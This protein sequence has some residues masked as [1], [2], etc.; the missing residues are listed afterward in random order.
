MKPGSKS[1]F[2]KAGYVLSASIV[3]LFLLRFFFIDVYRIPSESMMNK[4]MTDDY[5]LINKTAYSGYFSRF[6]TASPQQGDIFVFTINKDIPGFFVK[7]CIGL[8]GAVVAVKNG[9][10]SVNGKLMSEPR[11]V[12]HYYK[13]W[14]NDYQQVKTAIEEMRIDRFKNGFR[15]FPHY[16]V[17]ALD[18]FQKNKMNH[19]VDSIRIWNRK[20]DPDSAKINLP[21]L[22]EN[23]LD[24]SSLKIPFKGMTIYF[25]Q[26]QDTVYSNAIRMYEDSSFRL[27]SKAAFIAG[28]QVVA[29]TFKKDYFFMMGDNR[30]IAI[31]S[32]HYGFIPGD[33]LIGKFIQQF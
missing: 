17:L 25:S 4:L 18:N 32:R 20:N 29:Y 9:E 7:R 6:I 5:I 27:G 15:H 11:S 2:I 26:P 8:P 31:D 14:F 3:T 24:M 28:K 23:I 13:I 30:D 1:V 12:R 33:H 22:S 19:G 21:E 10:V 16:I